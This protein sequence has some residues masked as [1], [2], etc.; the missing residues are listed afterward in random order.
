MSRLIARTSSRTLGPPANSFAP[1]AGYMGKKTLKMKRAFE[2]R[3]VSWG[4]PSIQDLL[5]EIFDQSN[6]VGVELFDPSKAP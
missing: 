3:L 5:R 4:M 2:L 6:V 1:S